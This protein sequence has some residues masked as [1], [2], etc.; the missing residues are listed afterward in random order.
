MVEQ[1]TATRPIAAQTIAVYR[2]VTATRC[3]HQLR[4]RTWRTNCPTCIASYSTLL[5]VIGH[6]L[7]QPQEFIIV[8][9]V[10][11]RI[12]HIRSQDYEHAITRKPLLRCPDLRRYVKPKLGTVEPYVIACLAVVE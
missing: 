11:V 12:I 8:F 5:N 1:V 10:F 9:D 3:S 4:C 7:A 6:A 2:A